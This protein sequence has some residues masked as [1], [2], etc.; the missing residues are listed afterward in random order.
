MI[1]KNGSL[2]A[3]ALSPHCAARLTRHSM[4]AGSLRHCNR[5]TRWFTALYRLGMHTFLVRPLNPQTG[6]YMKLG[7]AHFD[8][9]IELSKILCCKSNM[10][11]WFLV[12]TVPL[13]RGQWACLKTTADTEKVRSTQSIRGC[14]A[15]HGCQRPQPCAPII[16]MLI[17]TGR[18]GGC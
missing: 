2:S 5:R 12:R 3:F 16:F 13:A 15:L 4:I 10:K 1:V 11:M 7:A 9:A 6:T 17:D 8:T 14:R 18:D